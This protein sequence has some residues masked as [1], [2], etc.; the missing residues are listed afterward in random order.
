MESACFFGKKFTKS[1]EF[2]SL[3]PGLYPSTLD[4]VEAMNTLIQERH[5]QNGSCFTVIMSRRAQ[6]LRLTLQMK[7][8]GQNFKSNFGNDLGV[9][10]QE[11]VPQ[12]REFTD[13]IVRIHPPMTC[14]EFA[15]YNIV[16]DTKTQ[17]LRCF[18]FIPKLKTG[19]FITTG[20]YM[21]YQTS[22]N[23]PFRQ[24]LKNSFHSNHNALGGTSG[25]KYRLYLSVRHVLFWRLQ[26]A[27]KTNSIRKPLQDG[28]FKTSGDSVL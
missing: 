23:L 7:D 19:D 16:G 14:T 27:L 15:E 2:Y 21:N 12:K 8:H 9:M 18:L 6:N 24:Q 13:D 17:L 28:C 22:C 1:S 5:N 26:K 10:L 25:E 11:K 20:Q 4:I 3:E